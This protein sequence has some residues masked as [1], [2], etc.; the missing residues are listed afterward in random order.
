[1]ADVIADHA[2]EPTCQTPAMSEVV[3]TPLDERALARLLDA[4]VVGADPLEVMPPVD[5]PPNWTPARR[6][7]F[8]EFHRGRSLNPETAVERTWVVDVDGKAA[9]AARLEFRGDAVEAGL[10][11][12]REWR[13][14]GIGRKV[15]ML[16]PDE[17]RSCGAAVLAATTTQDNHGALALLIAAGAALTTEGSTVTATLRLDT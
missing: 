8:S 12:S 6:T 7:F 11:L 9:G 3:L 10:W 2:G 4:A 5:G 1:M 17:A 14:R 13:G 16:L 15:M